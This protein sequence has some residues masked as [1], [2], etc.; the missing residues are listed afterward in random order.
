MPVVHRGR[1]VGAVRITQS[2]AAVDRAVRRST[3]GLVAIGVLVLL[4]GLGAAVFIAG[5]IAGPLRRLE[6]A[7]Q[8]VTA[9][10]L[11]TRADSRAAPSSAASR[12]PS[13][14]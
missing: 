13:T 7:A 9:G 1:T 11:D 2:V 3:A 14:R 4:A 12:A 6:G 10:Q 8:R 5:Q